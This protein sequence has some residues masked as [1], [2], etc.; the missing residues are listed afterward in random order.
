MTQHY[1]LIND[2]SEDYTEAGLVC[3]DGR[4]CCKCGEKGNIERTF[5][6]EKEKMANPEGIKSR[7]M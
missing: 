4:A 7:K 1:R 2:R 6:K 5:L 3:Q